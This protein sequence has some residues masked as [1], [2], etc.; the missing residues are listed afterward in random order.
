MGT[1][2]ADGELNGN[3]YFRLNQQF[4]IFLALIKEYLRQKN[5]L[6]MLYWLS[7]HY[8]EIEKI[9]GSGMVKILVLIEFITNSTSCDKLSV[10]SDVQYLR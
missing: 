1:E 6:Q 3:D 5:V 7:V 4:C 2:L 9:M 8:N 10:M